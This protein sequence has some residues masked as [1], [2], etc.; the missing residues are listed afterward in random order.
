MKKKSKIKNL[1]IDVDGVMTD[2]KI[3]YSDKGKILKCFGPDDNDALSVLKN[4]INILFVSADKRG[5]KITKKRIKSDMG[6]KVYL[7]SN[8]KRF[9]WI[10]KNFRLDET[11]Y[12]ADGIYDKKVMN[13]VAYS[14]APKNSDIDTYKK[15]RFKL[16]RNG[17]DRAV[18]E[19]CKVILNKFYGYKDITKI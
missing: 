19:A 16:K 4:F 1:I 2:G 11:I 6:F 17:G 10:K 18:S 14:F 9:E 5:F 7:V 13:R 15:A 3:Y 8:I 12:I